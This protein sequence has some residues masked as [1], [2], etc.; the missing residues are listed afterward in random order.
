MK[1]NNL[2]DTGISLLKRI[3]SLGYEAYIVGG[4]PRDLILGKASNDVDIATNCPVEILEKNFTTYKI[5][6]SKNFGILT[7]RWAEFMFEVAQF[8]SDGEYK[9]GRRPDNVEIV[10]DF[11]Q[12]IVRRDFTINAVGLS[13]NGG[14]IDHVGGISDIRKR[15]VK[16]VGD[17][18]KRFQEDHLRMIRAARFAAPE[19]FSLEKET[20]EAIIILA[21]LIYKVSAE[22]MRT[23]LIKAAEKPG[24]QFARFILIL[25]DLTLLERIL[26][27]VA[28]L[29]HYKHNPEHHPEGVTV[30]DHTIRCLEISDDP[31]LSKLAILFHDIGKSLTME[32]RD[33]QPTYHRHE[34]KSA[35]MT[36]EI[37]E[38]LKFSSDDSDILINAVADHMKF[39]KIL[40]MRPSKIARLVNSNHF[41]TLVDVA[42]ADEFSRGK[43]FAYFNQFPDKIKRAEEIKT[44]WE[45]RL[46][47]KSER[48]VSG[49][50]IME[51]V[52]I[53]PGPIVGK[54]IQQVEDHIIDNELDP[55]DDKLMYELILRAFL[56]GGL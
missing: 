30:M 28:C 8:R 51:I 52:G 26:P 35:E 14:F 2:L 18:Y 17:P 13:S 7:V 21:E 40:E 5:G 39:H 33:G 47:Q 54:I 46:T 27:E 34:Q 48:L 49:N 43:K 42:R 12:D 6:K 53:K 29:K 15:I 41:D 32:E 37:C 4:T 19:D 16:A 23:E 38:R 11:K 9:D 25:D 31:H 44:R 10:R 20:R 36:K 55:T 24:P 50:R 3:E 1:T 22:R 45:G 56:M